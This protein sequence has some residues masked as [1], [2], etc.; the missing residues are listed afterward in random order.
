MKRASERQTSLD[1]DAGR[2]PKKKKTGKALQQKYRSECAELWSCLAPSTKGAT[3]VHC[4]ACVKDLSCSHGE[5]NDCKKHVTVNITVPSTGFMWKKTAETEDQ[6]TMQIITAEVTMCEMIA[7]LNLPL[8][9][10]DSLTQAF[11]QMFPD[12]KIA[13]GMQCVQNKTTGVIK[14]VAETSLTGFLIVFNYLHT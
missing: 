9:T 3:F 7:D 13:R 1:N 11:R 10:A 2:C 5:K 8:S 12:S 6:L 4:K 14:E